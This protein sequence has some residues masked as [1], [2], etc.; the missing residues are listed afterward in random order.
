MRITPNGCRVW[1]VDSDADV[2][3]DATDKEVRI[4][5]DEV[6]AFV[7]DPESYPET[8]S[9]TLLSS[10][11]LAGLSAM[12]GPCGARRTTPSYGRLLG[13]GVEKGIDMRW[14][15]PLVAVSAC[16]VLS[17]CASSETSSATLH[18]G[19]GSTPA[20]SPTA[21]PSST[22]DCYVASLESMYASKALSVAYQ[23]GRM[24][25]DVSISLMNIGNPDPAR[26]GTPDGSR[27][28]RQ[29]TNWTLEIYTP[30]ETTVERQ[31]IGQPPLKVYSEGGSIGCDRLSGAPSWSLAPGTQAIV[32]SSPP[33]GTAIPIG[34][35]SVTWTWQV[36]GDQ[37]LIPQPPATVG[38]EFQ[39]Q[40]ANAMTYNGAKVAGS[41][42]SLSALEDYL[43]KQWHPRVG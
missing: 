28:R 15:S 18:Q 35:H 20:V 3:D 8:N 29:D 34:W 40:P 16:L 31:L 9:V 6:L 21:A 26:Y 24:P 39:A 38:G 4:L 12:Y 1:A 17:S 32:V 11:E 14:L 27:Y 5:S 41:S 43:I 13:K 23:F 22:E 2:L 10:D 7:D 19:A 37:V 33:L 36:V 25:S 30:W 42:I